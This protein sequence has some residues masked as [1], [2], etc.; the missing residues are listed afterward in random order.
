MS[1]SRLAI[2]VMKEGCIGSLPCSSMSHAKLDTELMR[3]RDRLPPAATRCALNLNFYARPSSSP[4]LVDNEQGHRTRFRRDFVRHRFLH[5]GLD[6]KDYLS[7]VVVARTPP[8][9]FDERHA[10]L[11]SHFEPALL[12]FHYGLPELDLLRRFRRRCDR[13]TTKVLVT[14]TTLPELLMAQNE[15][16]PELIDGVILQSP[17][18]AG[19]PIG[20]FLQDDVSLE[21]E[22]D[23]D[24]DAVDTLRRLRAAA[25]SASSSPSLPI[26]LAGGLSGPEKILEAIAYGAAGAM[27]GTPFLLCNETTASRPLRRAILADPLE[28]VER[29]RFYHAPFRPPHW[30]FQRGERKTMLTNAFSPLSG[31]L[32]RVIANDLL[33]K[34]VGGEGRDPA[35]DD[36]QTKAE[37]AALSQYSV[38]NL[39]SEEF[40][41]L[42][43]GRNYLASAKEM[44]ENRLFTRV[45]GGGLELRV[46]ARSVTRWLKSEL[47]SYL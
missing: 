32:D 47:A 40:A 26:V 34:D 36:P 27:V 24:C 22:R 37:I 16:F 12:T 30:R 46:G 14:V 11:V 25:S 44:K 33:E 29:E 7:R 9:F 10:D 6:E 45:G 1:D 35:L 28:M 42:P 19:G 13:D 5:F 8:N 21:S 39:N 15:W 38:R 2:E 20:S 18:S 43:A 3:I 31:R 41:Y 4:S 23:E 17:G